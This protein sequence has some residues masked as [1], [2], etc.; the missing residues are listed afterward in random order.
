M[1]TPV[2]SMKQRVMRTQFTRWRAMLDAA[3]A[4]VWESACRLSEVGVQ[5][6]PCGLPRIAGEFA[7]LL[8]YI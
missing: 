3:F 1:Q 7:P 6:P 8:G 5:T 2:A 4:L